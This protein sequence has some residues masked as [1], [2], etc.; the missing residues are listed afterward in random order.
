MST[1]EVPGAF[2]SWLDGTGVAQGQ[3]TEPEEIRL[4]AIWGNRTA[5]SRGTSTV[6][7]LDFELPADAAA[8]RELRSQAKSFLELFTGADASR[9]ERAG[10]RKVIERCDAAMKEN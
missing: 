4:G 1:I 9:A 7:R 10:A 5:R 8:L 6:D 3:G 2:G